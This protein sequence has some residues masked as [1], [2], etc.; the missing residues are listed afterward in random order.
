MCKGRERPFIFLNESHLCEK[1]PED[2]V[3][4][5][6]NMSQLCAVPAIKPAQLQAALTGVYSD[7]TEGG[8]C[9]PDQSVVYGVI[10]I[11]GVGGRY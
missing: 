3:E 7:E 1:D 11:S 10:F 9:I 8:H 4:H 6:L 5:R 2:L